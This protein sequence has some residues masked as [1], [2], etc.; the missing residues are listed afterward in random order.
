MKLF[1]CDRCGR[2]I[3][4]NDQKSEVSVNPNWSVPESNFRT[5]MD[6]CEICTRQ[7][8]SHFMKNK[9]LYK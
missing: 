9:P 1:K 6:L 3:G 7:F 8:F 5:T 4:Q 2:T